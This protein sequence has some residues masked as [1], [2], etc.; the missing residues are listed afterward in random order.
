MP[1]STVQIKQE[2]GQVDIDEFRPSDRGPQDTRRRSY[3]IFSS[4]GESLSTRDEYDDESDAEAD[5]QVDGYSSSEETY[6]KERI[7]RRAARYHVAAPHDEE[8]RKP[9]FKQEDH[10]IS[11]DLQRSSPLFSSPA[12]TR[13]GSWSR[14]STP[15][16]AS[17]ATHRFISH[18]SRASPSLRLQLR[19]RRLAAAFVAPH[20]SRSKASIYGE[21]RRLGLHSQ[22]LIDDKRRIFVKEEILESEVDS[23]DYGYASS[24]V[25]VRSNTREVSSRRP[26]P[27]TASRGNSEEDDLP[28]TWTEFYVGLTALRSLVDL[29]SIS[30]GSRSRCRNESKPFDVHQAEDIDRHLAIIGSTTNKLRQ[31]VSSHFPGMVNI[32]KPTHGSFE[33]NSQSSSA[34]PPI[35]PITEAPP[36]GGTMAPVQPDPAPPPA[37]LD[38][39]MVHDFGW[40]NSSGQ[41]VGVGLLPEAWGI[42]QPHAVLDGSG[43]WGPSHDPSMLQFL[44]DSDYVAP[45]SSNSTAALPPAILPGMAVLTQPPPFADPSPIFGPQNLTGIDLALYYSASDSFQLGL[46]TEEALGT[47]NPAEPSIP[48]DASASLDSYQSVDADNDTQMQDFD[49]PNWQQLVQLVE[50][51]P[52]ST[53]QSSFNSLS[54]IDHSQH[55][56]L[57]ENT[58]SLS[59][60]VASSTAPPQP[61]AETNLDDI[62]RIPCT[63]EGCG[64]TFRRPYLLRDH[65]RTHTGESNVYRC[66]YQGCTKSFGSQSNLTRHHKTHKREKATPGSE[67]H[68]YTNNNRLASP[69]PTTSLAPLAVTPRRSRRLQNTASNPLGPKNVH[70]ILDPRTPSSFIARAQKVP[71]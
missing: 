26:T 41:N 71:A 7:V 64:K 6:S 29:V 59:L 53:C 65:M 30:A 67:E 16:P 39:S 24:Q 45:M 34:N 49:S 51:Y 70:R 35:P 48:N 62:P 2:P 28:S 36:T 37:Q 18:S 68:S 20:S 61:A 57:A 58:S 10:L 47:L 23:S 5:D 21:T 12:P 15:T 69:A 63:F 50:S 40:H 11:D 54:S 1:H 43:G 27:V 38:E 14:S 55:P 4:T 13:E 66:T 56:S 32:D 31:I 9:F 8:D 60:E 19:H 44:P 46:I 33:S 17:N 42:T 22:E 25:V 3:S 52:D